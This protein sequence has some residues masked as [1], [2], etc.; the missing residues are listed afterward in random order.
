MPL[1]IQIV[2]LV[3]LSEPVIILWPLLLLNNEIM[4]GRIFRVTSGVDR[5]V[6]A[7]SH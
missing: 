3:V 4:D 5:T 2:E 1:S 7:V 6:L